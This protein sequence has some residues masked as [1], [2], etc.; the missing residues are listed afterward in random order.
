MFDYTT[1]IFFKVKYDFNPPQHYF[2]QDLR[3]HCPPDF[4][5]GF[6]SPVCMMGPYLLGNFKA[7]TN[8]L[9][10]MHRS[11]TCLVPKWMCREGRLHRRYHWDG[12]SITPSQ[13]AR[14]SF[15]QSSKVDALYIC[16]QVPRV[17]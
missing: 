2:I 11:L 15:P 6:L 3:D 4:R 1:P 17:P 13:W 14:E 5:R 8:R 12:L 9:N 10:S 7:V 16:K